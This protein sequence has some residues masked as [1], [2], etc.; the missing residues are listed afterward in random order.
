MITSL[1]ERRGGRMPLEAKSLKFK[2][3]IYH[4]QLIDVPTSKRLHTWNNHISG[5]QQIASTL[6]RFLFSEALTHARGDIFSTIL[7]AAGSDHWPIQLQ[8]EILGRGLHKLFQFEQFWLPHLGFKEMV[9]EWWCNITPHEGSKIYKV[10]QKLKIIKARLKHWNQHTFGNT[11]R[12]HR[13]L[14]ARMTSIQHTLIT[15]GRTQELDRQ[16]KHL[17]NPSKE[18]EVQEEILQKQKSKI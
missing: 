17:K 12:I 10:Q 4:N 3:F 5:S 2:D 9:V 7:P 8:W 15:F 1:R 14:E 11:F 18:R 6:D 16:E 13:D